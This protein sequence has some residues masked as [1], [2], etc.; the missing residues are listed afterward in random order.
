MVNKELCFE[1]RQHLLLFLLER[2]KN[3]RLLP[4]TVDP[5][6]AEFGISR[7]TVKGL[8]KRFKDTRAANPNNEWDVKSLRRNSG[9]RP[10]WDVEDLKERVRALAPADRRSICDTARNINVPPSTLVRLGVC[11][12]V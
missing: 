12:P 10:T 7:R 9:R 4:G 3:G 2:S 5:A 8:W 11:R 6:M 1:E